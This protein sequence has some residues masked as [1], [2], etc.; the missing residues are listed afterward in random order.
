M[1]VCHIYE[2][3]SHIQNE[4]FLLF[5]HIVQH[6]LLATILLQRNVDNVE[7]GAG[8]HWCN[9]RKAYIDDD[10]VWGLIFGP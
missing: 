9:Y 1:K 3:I 5:L 10:A 6:S 4:T 2:G 7:G 8:M